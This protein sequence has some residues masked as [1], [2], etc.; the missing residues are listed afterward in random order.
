MSVQKKTR[1][2]VVVADEERIRGPV[3]E[4]LRG[5]GY[6]VETT[7]G[8][9]VLLGYLC[10]H[11]IDVLI[12]DLNIKLSLNIKPLNGIKLLELFKRYSPDNPFILF[13]GDS[14]TKAAAE[15]MEKGA[16]T[17]LENDETL[18]ENILAA[19]EKGL[20]RFAAVEEERR[21]AIEEADRI[22][23]ERAKAETA[24][25]TSPY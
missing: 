3:A 11:G 2:I 19:V 15:A 18:I 23:L 1:K 8:D 20:E 21:L 24:K 22:I 16:F 14:D 10:F 7:R 4:A 25:K 17:F 6:D 13:A 12:S 9:F 5:R